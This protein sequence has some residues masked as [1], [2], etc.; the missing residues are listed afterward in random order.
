MQQMLSIAEERKIQIQKLQISL[1]MAT[2][3]ADELRKEVD[4]YYED[5]TQVG[6]IDYDIQEKMDL[7]RNQLMIALDN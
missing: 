1:Q 3:E 2:E 4:S 5:E 6:G 7:F